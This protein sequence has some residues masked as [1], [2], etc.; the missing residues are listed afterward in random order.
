MEENNGV[1]VRIQHL[2][3]FKIKQNKL[4]IGKHQIT[5][6]RPPQVSIQRAAVDKVLVS[7]LIIHSKA[8]NLVVY[9]QVCMDFLRVAVLDLNASQHTR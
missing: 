8:T 1:N 5:L 2:L 3:L 9:Q 7:K 6:E 4:S